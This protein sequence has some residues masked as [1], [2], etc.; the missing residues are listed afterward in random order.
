[1][2]IAETNF[3]RLQ[4]KKKTKTKQNRIHYTDFPG[5]RTKAVSQTQEQVQEK[6]YQDFFFLLTLLFSTGSLFVSQ[7]KRSQI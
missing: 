4:Q 6:H 5:T 3:I 7:P 1:M 2:V